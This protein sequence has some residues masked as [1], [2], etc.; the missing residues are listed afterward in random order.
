MRRAFCV[1]AFLA[2]P[3][4]AAAETSGSLRG[5]VVDDKG[6]ILPGAVVSVSSAVH[7]VTGR[8]AVANAAGEFLIQALPPAGDYEVRVSMPGYATVV[9]SGVD[10]SAGRVVSVRLVLSPETSVRQRVEV[11]A[12]PSI[13][14][15][16]DTTT[17]T[18][19]SSEFVDMLPILGRDYQDAL[20]LAP[21][22]TDV[23]GDG[24]PNIHGARDTDVVTLVD[25]VSTTDP[26]TGKVGAQL[27]IES[28]QEIQIKTS[29]ATAEY[30][31]AQGGFADIVTKSG[32]NEFQGTFKFFWR[33]SALDGDGAGID[34]PRLH[35]GVGEI[36]LRT[37]HFNDY[38]PFL[39][40]GGPI[41]KDR[42]WFYVANESI[43]KE[44]PVNA[45][46]AA[47]VRGTRE[48]R[49]F[50]KLTWQASAAQR[51]ALSFNY[52]PQEYLNEGLN[53]FTREEAG[54]TDRQGGTVLTLKSTAVLSP[55][56]AIETSLSAFDQTPRLDPNLGPDTNGNGV[57]WIDRNN[58]GFIEASE[59]D[60]GEDYDGDQQFDVF[61]DL[62]HNGRLD[63][64]E[65]LDGDGT[66]T[67]VCEGALR[68]DLNCNGRLDPGEDRNKNGVLDDTPL[69]T[70]L[71][72]YGRLRPLEPDQDYSI[73]RNTGLITGPYYENLTDQRRRFTFRQDLSLFVPDFRG[74]HDFKIGLDLE[75]ESFRR[76]TQARDIVSPYFRSCT[77]PDC[78]QQDRMLENPFSPPLSP[79][80]TISTLLP[81]GL[82]VQNEAVGFTAGFYVQDVYHPVPNLSLGIGLRFDRERAQAP[83]YSSFDPA[84]EGGHFERLLDLGGF[85][86][87]DG[88]YGIRAD[89][90][91]HGPGSI[92]AHT[93]F[94]TTPL[95]VAALSR[96][97]RHHSV[98]GFESQELTS[99]GIVPDESAGSLDAL[100]VNGVTPQIAETFAIT[101]NNLAPRLSVSWDPTADGRTKLFATWGRYYDKLF[102]NTIVGE[103]GPDWINRYYH[104]DPDNLTSSLVPDHGIGTLISK[105]PPS[106]TQVD[107]GLQTPFSDEFTVGFEREI[108][109]E[110]SLSLTFIDRHY[111]KQLQDIDLNHSLRLDSKGQ[112]L[113]TFGIKVYTA[114]ARRTI[115][116]SSARS[117]PDGRPDLYIYDL[118]FNQILR[119]GNY[120]DARYHGIE[121][122]LTRR[123]ARRWEMQAS[124]T[125]S[126]ALGSAEDFESRLGNDPST[127]EWEFGYLDYDQRHV[128]KL[129]TAVFL[130]RDWQV[131][132]SMSWSSGLPYSIISRFFALDNVGY[133]QYRTIYGYTAL[134]PGVG[135]KFVP[136]RRNSERNAAVLDINLQ[137]RK[138]VVIG[139]HAASLS[140]EVFNLLNRDD[141]RI[142]TFEPA[143][144]T[145][146]NLPNSTNPTPVGPLQINGERRFG[147][148][149]QLG[150]RYDF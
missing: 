76:Q 73:N 48:L 87:V 150:I 109:P 129:N 81:T 91:F 106:A 14:N 32:G 101:N 8:A 12:T 26:L 35:A 66:L 1:L 124:Y 49:E 55:L 84:V 125:Y 10:V 9:L 56:T 40:I 95:Q 29:G 119:V 149:I 33:G 78:E 25:G 43:S 46:N 126:R 11:R 19:L 70:S 145:L 68:E 47:F 22:V 122:A 24:N 136:L 127:V 77:P 54:Y 142:F 83:G 75:R 88:T 93:E 86:V 92:N 69:P 85:R 23:D 100:S 59:R 13:V 67:T 61:E 105:A 41:V 108:A 50:V 53:S 147:R 115:D 4:A 89:P 20:T 137:A 17:Q 18:R 123:L 99:L 134:D 90:I 15:L 39:A 2:L 72:P 51:L 64:G 82:D 107:R 63:K 45:L 103:Q 144:N 131:G 120:N 112:P 30:S 130:P 114:S 27:N 111:R 52:D 141:L 118:F 79:V 146:N 96:L 117:A 74:S 6:S 31:R 143:L 132:A 139:R 94:I 3:A 110:V 138:D 7:A 140:I 133:E 44:D 104:R 97:T 71:Y 128:V 16:E 102:L 36:G 42:A 80:N 21:G 28:I 5:T 37:L 60:P 58:N 113:D 121:L 38:L 135:V 98:V 62:N 148:R 65:D 34:D 116:F 57:L